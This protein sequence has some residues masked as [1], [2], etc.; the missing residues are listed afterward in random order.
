MPACEVM[1]TRALEEATRAFAATPTR[2]WLA[3][4]MPTAPRCAV[5]TSTTLA[6]MC[7]IE[8]NRIAATSPAMSAISMIASAIGTREIATLP[9]AMCGTETFVIATATSIVVIAT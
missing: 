4:A 2:V 6:A 1:P 3:T 7:A 5:P 9:T 8:R